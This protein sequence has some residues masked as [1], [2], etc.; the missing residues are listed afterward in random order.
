MVSRSG[1]LFGRS[2]DEGGFIAINVGRLD[3][4]YSG[5][6]E[7]MSC[8]GGELPLILGGFIGSLPGP[9]GFIMGKIDS[10]SSSM[11]LLNFLKSKNL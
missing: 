7:D 1:L 10:S 2:L 4:E 9:A 11:K 5:L 8:L 3:E 6:I